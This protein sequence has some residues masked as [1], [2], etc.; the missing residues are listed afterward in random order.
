MSAPFLIFL[1]CEFN[2]AALADQIYLYLSGI[3][4]FVFN[5]LRD[6]SR[7]DNHFLIVDLLRLYHEA[8]FAARLYSVGF[9][10]SVK[11]SAY[12]LQL[13]KTLDV[14]LVILASCAWS[15]CGYSVCRLYQRRYY[16]A[17][18]YV[19]VVSLYRVDN[20]RRFLVLLTYVYA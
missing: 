16:G 6:L 15:C 17:R 19:A 3:I 13:F 2:D 9:F 14:V 7:Y 10:Y 11:R 4:H 8:Y 12:L 1:P 18:F 20:V 5:L